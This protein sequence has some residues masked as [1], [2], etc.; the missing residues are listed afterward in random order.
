MSWSAD[1]S[2]SI[3]DESHPPHD[4]DNTNYPKF[5]RSARVSSPTSSVSAAR[6]LRY[7]PRRQRR[8]TQPYLTER[9]LRNGEVEREVDDGGHGLNQPNPGG[10]LEA[11]TNPYETLGSRAW[12]HYLQPAKWKFHPCNSLQDP[13]IFY[14]GPTFKAKAVVTRELQEGVTKFTGYEALGRCFEKLGPA[15]L[16][17]RAQQAQE[18]ADLQAAQSGV[19]RANHCHGSSVK[20]IKKESL[21]PTDPVIAP[22]AAAENG[23]NRIPLVEAPYSQKP[24]A[25]VPEPQALPANAATQLPEATVVAPPATANAATPPGRTMPRR[26]MVL[27]TN[28]FG[29]TSA[30]FDLRTRLIQMEQFVWGKE[31]TGGAVQRVEQLEQFADIAPPL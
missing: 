26:L 13:Y 10:G 29:Q 7:L 22:A 17:E 23:D 11:N 30:D 4:S 21:A 2:S 19:D 27:E 12:Y 18:A 6:P 20:R 28:L 3:G 15:Q 25:A 31:Q 5:R 1:R 24:R 14:I 16:L 8:P 9:G